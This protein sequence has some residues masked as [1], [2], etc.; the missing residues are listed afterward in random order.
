MLQNVMDKVKEEFFKRVDQ[1]NGWGKNEIKQ[2]YLEATHA[3]FNQILDGIEAEKHL[4]D[5]RP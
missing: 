5:L 4:G 3:V 2:Q 1:K